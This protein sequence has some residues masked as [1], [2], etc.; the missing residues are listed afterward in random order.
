MSTR[1]NFDESQQAMVCYSR[2]DMEGLNHEEIV[3]DM[4]A[5][6]AKNGRHP[7][8]LN[9]RKVPNI[10]LRGRYTYKKGENDQIIR[11]E[12]GCPAINEWV[13]D[14]FVMFITNAKDRD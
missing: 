1:M 12:N 7:M 14:E 4:V 5:K 13:E 6:A 10:Y 3:T 2:K 11:D 9:S 8:D